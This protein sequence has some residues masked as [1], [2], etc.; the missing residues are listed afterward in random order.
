LVATDGVAV[1]VARDLPPGLVAA[2]CADA[3]AIGPRVM[4]IDMR[5]G[6]P[7][8]GLLTLG[9]GVPPRTRAAIEEALQ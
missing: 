2:A 6:A 7:M 9:Y 1:I 4:T 5:L 8:R 3:R